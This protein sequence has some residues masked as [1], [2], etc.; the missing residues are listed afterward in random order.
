MGSR[1]ADTPPHPWFIGLAIAVC[2]QHPA[3]LSWFFLS[4]LRYSHW[5]A[6]H[7]PVPPASVALTGR[8]LL[9]PAGSKS[10]KPFSF[11][12]LLLERWVSSSSFYRSENRLAGTSDPKPWSDGCRLT[13][14]LLPPGV[15]PLLQFHSPSSGNLPLSTGVSVGLHLLTTL[16]CFSQ[17][18]AVLLS[19]RFSFPGCS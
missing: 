16:W 10:L 7:S 19:S 1:G 4:S 2:L 8:H 9:I 15:K 11:L 3:E 12:H 6:G 17:E 5:S 18:E 14:S 13:C